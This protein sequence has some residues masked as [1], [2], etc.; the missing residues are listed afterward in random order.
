MPLSIITMLLDARCCHA[1]YA[2]MP[3]PYAYAAADAILL[4][5]DGCH[6]VP[7][8]LLPCYADFSLPCCS[9]IDAAFS[10][11]MPSFFFLYDD[12]AARFRR[13]A[14]YF[15]FFSFRHD[16]ADTRRHA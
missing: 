5:Y 14:D 6:A 3:P 8:L 4:A 7:I 13:H 16:A 12:A 11:A 9:A 1:D 15:R 2:A 10:A